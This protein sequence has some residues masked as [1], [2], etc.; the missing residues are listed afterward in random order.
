MDDSMLIQLYT[1]KM[2]L[3]IVAFPSN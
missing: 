1:W 3:S 2:V